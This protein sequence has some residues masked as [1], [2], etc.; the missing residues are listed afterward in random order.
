MFI[1]LFIFCSFSLPFCFFLFFFG[2][3]SSIVTWLNCLMCWPFRIECATRSKQ[4]PRQQQQ[5][6]AWFSNRTSVV[7][8]VSFFL[9]LGTV[10]VRGPGFVQPPN[11]KWMNGSFKKIKVLSLSL[12][13]LTGGAPCFIFFLFSCRIEKQGERESHQKEQRETN[14][15]WRRFSF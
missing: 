5:Q 1:Y 15:K 10:R 6:M 3:S 4:Q 13:K 14:N 11:R 9:K 2:R 7:F 12:S 8:V